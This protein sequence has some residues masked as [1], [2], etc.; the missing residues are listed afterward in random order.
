MEK[1]VNAAEWHKKLEAWK[2]SGKT[3]SEFCREH[4]I[5]MST[6]DYW[7]R[8]QK[9]AKMRVP[10]F[11]KMPLSVSTGEK[12]AKIRIVVDGRYSVE[13]N[14]GFETSDLI[15]VLQAIGSVSCL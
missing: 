11:V 8:K 4:G 1:K 3:R 2:S 12:T 5:P 15:T 6:F 10:G 14:A 13:L 9:G 7:K